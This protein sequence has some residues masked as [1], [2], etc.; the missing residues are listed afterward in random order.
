MIQERLGNTVI[1]MEKKEKGLRSSE[2]L[3]HLP[4]FAQH[5][6]LM[7]IILLYIFCYLLHSRIGSQL[8]APPSPK[9]VYHNMHCE[10]LF[11]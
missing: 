9:S 5:M 11:S 1:N 4:F 8:L 6:M 7:N 10:T 3:K 2:G